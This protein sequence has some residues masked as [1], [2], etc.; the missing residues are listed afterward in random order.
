LYAGLALTP[1]GI[2]VVEFNA[3]FGDPEIQVVLDRLVTPLG[4]L[5]QRCA[6]GGLPEDTRLEWTPGAAVAVVVAAENYPA[7]PVKGDVIAGIEEADAIPGA[8]VLHAGTK[9]SGRL[10]VA[11]GGRVLNVVGT[12]PDLAT[13]R[14]TAYEA[15]GKIRL[16]GMQH[17]TD[18]A[19]K[20]AASPS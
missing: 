15:V 11:A 7:D 2:R 10:P 12:G 17:R 1:A 4:T 9:Y 16:R 3:R 14:A 18:I 19:E 13:A 5:L 8:Y 20:A 6:I